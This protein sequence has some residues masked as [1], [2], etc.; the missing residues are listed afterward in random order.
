VAGVRILIYSGLIFGFLHAAF[1]AQAPGGT[2]SVTAPKLLSKVD[3]QYTREALAAK[4][5]G[6]VVLVVLINERGTAAVLRVAVPLGYGLDEMAKKCV[7]QWRFSPAMKDGLPVPIQAT[8]EVRFR[9]VKK[10]ED[11]DWVEQERAT[12]LDLANQML[13]GSDKQRA[14]AVEIIQRLS[15]EKYLPG[16]W[17]EYNLLVAG[18]LVPQD[19]A[20]ARKLLEQ[21]ASKHFPPALFALAGQELEPSGNRERGLKLLH[22]A[23]ELGVAEAQFALARRAEEGSDDPRS[24]DDARRYYRLCAERAHV[25]CQLRFAKLQLEQPGLSPAAR[26]EAVAW[27]ILAARLGAQPAEALLAQEKPRLSPAELAAAE[28]LTSQLLRRQ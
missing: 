26:T 28:A 12:R 8:I 11:I 22:E 7:E 13:Q 6:T 9:I 10:K 21:A 23:S 15:K 1:C 17:A 5:E 16:I 2:P 27:L 18:K 14:S 24:P 25:S 19:L 4:L 3:P 20:R